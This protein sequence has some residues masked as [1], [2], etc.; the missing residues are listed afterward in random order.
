MEV[1]INKW[2]VNA[3]KN[4]VHGTRNGMSG[5]KSVLVYMREGVCGGALPSMFRRS[6]D[7]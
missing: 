1:K 4:C 6:C 2:L 5:N 3:D 7:C